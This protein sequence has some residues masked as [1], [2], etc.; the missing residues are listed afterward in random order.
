M[1]SIGRGVHRG[2]DALVDGLVTIAGV[3][4]TVTADL[5]IAQG[6]DGI[7]LTTNTPLELSIREFGRNDP[8]LALMD[9]CLHSSVDDGVEVGV[10]LILL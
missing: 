2:M 6:Q 9:L 10:G 7:R 4:Q 1:A 5:H 8:L 3:T